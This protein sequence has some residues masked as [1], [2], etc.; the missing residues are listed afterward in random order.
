[1]A[2]F[3]WVAPRS[4]P[5]HP[6]TSLRPDDHRHPLRTSTRQTRVCLARP[7]R[8]VR[9]GVALTRHHRKK[10]LLLSTMEAD[11][12]AVRA[13]PRAQVIHPSAL[14]LSSVTTVNS[15]AIGDSF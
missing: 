6:G 14:C 5:P 1:M 11:R 2:D 4:R 8:S 7:H 10:V 12:G 3:R 9:G 13:F 15:A